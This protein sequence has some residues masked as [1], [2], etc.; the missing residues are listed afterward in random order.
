MGQSITLALAFPA[1]AR[2]WVRALVAAWSGS[3]ENLNLGLRCFV[4]VER[5]LRVGGEEFFMWGL[6]RAYVAFFER[7]GQV[8]W[9]TLEHLNFMS[10]CFCEL[11]KL[12]PARAYYVL[13]GYLRSLALQLQSLNSLKGK[14]KSDLTAKLYSQQTLQILKLLAQVVGRVGHEEISA[15]AYPLAEVINSYEHIS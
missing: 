13:F 8:S 10:N 4:G 7:C 3:G 15:L 5:G 2:K 12:N 9:R 1:L 14:F 11:V 6:R